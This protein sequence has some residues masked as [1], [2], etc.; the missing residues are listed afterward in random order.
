LS[1]DLLIFGTSF[2]NWDLINLLHCLIF[3]N[4][5]CHRNIFNSF[6][7]Y[8]FNNLSLIWYLDIINLLLIIS[9]SFL[10]WNRFNMRLRWRLRLLESLNRDFALILRCKLI[11]TH[12]VLMIRCHP[13]IYVI[14]IKINN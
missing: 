3:S 14:L 7:R 8:L 1:L 6:L 9:V 5:F 13:G 11:L 4:S 2:L 10:N 12:S